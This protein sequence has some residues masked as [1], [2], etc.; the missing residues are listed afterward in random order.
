MPLFLQQ[1]NKIISVFNI[2]KQVCESTEK[3]A[4]MVADVAL[5]SQ[6]DIKGLEEV[7]ADLNKVTES[8]VTRILY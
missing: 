5:Q 1:I 4:Y 7:Q 8:I 3:I 6:D 2:V